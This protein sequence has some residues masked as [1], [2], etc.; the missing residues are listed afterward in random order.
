[1]LPFLKFASD[2]KEHSL[3]EALQHING[4]FGLT[5]EEKRETLP[6]GLQPII[7]NRVGWARTYLKKAGLIES[8][9]RGYFRITNRGLEVLKQNPSEI[10]VR[11]LMQFAEFVEFQTI[12]KGE[13]KD[14]AQKTIAESLDPMEQLEN[15][16]Q[17][18]QYDSIHNIT[19][20]IA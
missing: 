6:S 9:R 11:F 13:K 15:S 18:A 3:S 10:N 20:S 2:R 7:D 19:V 5:E 17:R 12:K 8:T 4:L 1:M 14:Q 16:F